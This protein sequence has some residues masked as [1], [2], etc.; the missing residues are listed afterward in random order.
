MKSKKIWWNCSNRYIYLFSAYTSRM[1]TM[2]FEEEVTEC[3]WN[4]VPRL[5]TRG[6]KW[7]LL[8]TFTRLWI[9]FGSSMQT[10]CHNGTTTCTQN[11][12][13]GQWHLFSRRNYDFFA[14]IHDPAKPWSSFFKICLASRYNVMAEWTFNMLPLELNLLSLIL[15]KT[16]EGKWRLIQDG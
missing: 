10:L 11:V 7:L 14:V 12:F 4:L 3:A 6:W 8:M 9:E 13:R 1:T 5:V 15:P 2:I 16:L